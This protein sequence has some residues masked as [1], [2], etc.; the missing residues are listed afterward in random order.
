MRPQCGTDLLRSGH[1]S[2]RPISVLVR[3]LVVVVDAGDRRTRTAAHA[4]GRAIRG[5]GGRHQGPGLR[6]FPGERAARAPAMVRSRSLAPTKRA[7]RDRDVS[8]LGQRCRAGATRGRRRNRQPHRFYRAHRVPDRPGQHGLR[9]VPGQLDR[10]LASLAGHVGIFPALLSFRC[11]PAR[12]LRCLAPRLSVARRTFAVCRRPAAFAGD[13]FVH[14]R[15]QFRG[16]AH[17]EPISSA[18]VGFHRR[19]YRRRRRQTCLR[20]AAVDQIRCPRIRFDRR[21]HRVLSLCRHRCR[22][23]R[24]SAL[25]RGALAGR[26]CSPRRYDRDLWS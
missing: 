21:G 22:V 5:G 3:V 1:Q 25:R 17:R 14:G 18:A 10:P 9:T 24:R 7:Q 19:L 2:G 23:R 13:D 26:Q 16:A 6:H 4:L 8:S 11:G 20:V 15:I 12:R